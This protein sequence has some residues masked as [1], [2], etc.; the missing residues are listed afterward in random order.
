MEKGREEKACLLSVEFYLPDRTFSASPR[1]PPL[2]MLSPQ[3]LRTTGTKLLRTL[4]TEQ[5]EERA[6]GASFPRHRKPTAWRVLRK[7]QTDTRG[8]KGV[9]SQKEYTGLI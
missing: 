8:E 1:Y 6:K 2:V 7:S 5:S 3:A 4:R 9:H